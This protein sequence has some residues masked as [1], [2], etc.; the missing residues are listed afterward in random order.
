MK[1]PIR[2]RILD[3]EYL[4][5][6]DEDPEQVSEIAKLV[7]DKLDL[8]RQNSEKLSEGK[9]AILAAFEIA[10]DYLRLV[11]ERDILLQDVQDRCRLMNRQIESLE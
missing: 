8:V 3:N 5:K 2:I 6:S 9:T 4:L 11:K 10:G 7:N 1:N